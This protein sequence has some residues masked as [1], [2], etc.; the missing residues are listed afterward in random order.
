M[1]VNYFTPMLPIR[2]LIPYTSHYHYYCKDHL[3]NNRVVVDEDGGIEQISHYY[4]YGGLFGD[5]N[6]SHV[7][8]RLFV[9]DVK[10]NF[11]TP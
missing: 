7:F 5:V 8:S 4:P 2:V 6:T 9:E 11:A 3:G 10:K 1:V